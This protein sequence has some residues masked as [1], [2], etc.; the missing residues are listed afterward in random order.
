MKKTNHNKDDIREIFN[1]IEKNNDLSWSELA[2]MT[3]IEY[4]ES[5]KIP[6]YDVELKLAA[7]AIEEWKDVA[8]R[9]YLAK[10]CHKG[11][12]L[13]ILAEHAYLQMQNRG[14]L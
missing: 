14:A 8:R 5:L 1:R 2:V 3:A 4:A 11:E 10:G 13:R 12:K 7:S 6:Q 9:L